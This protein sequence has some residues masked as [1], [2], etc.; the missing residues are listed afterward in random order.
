VG[1]ASHRWGRK[2]YFK[3]GGRVVTSQ[4][5]GGKK[6]KVKM[7]Y[8]C[9]EK[10]AGRLETK[11]NSGKKHRRGENQGQKKG[12]KER[13][14]YGLGRLMRGTGIERGLRA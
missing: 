11:N 9:Q 13:A 8:L 4:V 6:K 1:P 2:T 5:P 14:P 10:G 3:K 12:K 7:K